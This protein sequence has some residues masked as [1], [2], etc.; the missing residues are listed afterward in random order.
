MPF[1]RLVP[2]LNLRNVPV[3][4]LVAACFG[5][6]GM[7][8][9]GCA[10]VPQGPSVTQ[11]AA[12]SYAQAFDVVCA[13]AK[14]AGFKVVTADRQTGVIETA[15]AFM[16]SV[17]EPWEWN[18]MTLSQVGE[19]SLSFERRRLRFEFQLAGFKESA[20]NPDAPIAGPVI[21]GSERLAPVDLARTESALEL[22]VVVSVERRFQ[23]GAQRNTWTR[24]STGLMTDV[25]EEDNGAVARDQSLWTP[26][27]RDERLELALLREVESRLAK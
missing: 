27:E 10:S 24:A 17:V 14:E 25:T 9:A 8:F 20:T 15:P 3:P 7:L 18:D 26:V 5:L 23:P 4:S 16:G 21:A 2:V 6:V 22:R 19:A 1:S 11:V 12:A 13:T